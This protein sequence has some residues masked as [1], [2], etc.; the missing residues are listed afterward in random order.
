MATD[1]I[2]AN[3]NRT[4]EH[5]A[6][7]RH[8][9]EALTAEAEE[10]MRAHPRDDGAPLF[11]YL[12]YNVA[13][14]PLQPLARHE[15]AERVFFNIQ[16]AYGECRGTLIDLKVPKGATSRELSEAT[17]SAR[18]SSRRWPSAC[19]EEVLKMDAL[20]CVHTCRISGGGSI[21]AW[22]SASTLFFFLRDLGACRPRTP[23]TYIGSKG[24]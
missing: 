17:L 10:V 19:A 23:R 4:Y 5:F 11:L 12:S 2:R 7:S 15:A 13:H 3:E 22:S 6:E 24:T 9:T 1:W 21:A 14:S 16:H 18:C 8:C 20:G